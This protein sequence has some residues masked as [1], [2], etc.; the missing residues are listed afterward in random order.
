MS[1]H[2]PS[3]TIE[4]D[5]AIRDLES[6]RPRARA[7]AA[8]ALGDVKDADQRRMACTALLRVLTDE[9]AEVRAEAALSLG[10]LGQ[11]RAVEPLVGRLSDLSPVVRQG[12]A[13]ALGKLGFQ[14]AFE[15][16]V[17]VLKLGA[18]D[19]RFQA[20]TSLVEIDAKRAYD[21]LVA[22]M[23]DSDGEVLGAIALALATVGDTRAAGHICRLLT[24][25]RRQTRFDAAYALAEL[26]DSRG[27]R[28]LAECASDRDLGWDAVCALHR[29]GG[30]Q[31]L[32]RLADLCADKHAPREVIL[33]GASAYL[34]L[35]GSSHDIQ[36]VL[37]AGLN[38]RKL[39]HRALA[40]EELGKVGGPWA[41]APLRR[42]QG[43]F[44]ARSLRNEVASALQ[45]IEQRTANANT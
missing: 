37:L 34:D 43:R 21:P 40:V 6:K 11:Q 8:H 26:N 7:A 31:V 4:F 32:T 20:A 33:R 23:G 45:A 36:A 35:G 19:V 1:L 16:L 17:E 3:L 9:R 29:L 12:S 41:V 10:E 24:H 18:A 13:I 22:A 25:E 30:D 5:A 38:A 44:R 42:F 27:L 15:P 28:V 14:T 2:P 39:E